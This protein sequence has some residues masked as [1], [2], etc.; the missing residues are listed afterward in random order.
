MTNQLWL[1]PMDELNQNLM[2]NVR[3]SDWTN[4]TPAPK[5]N[6]VVIGAGSAGLVTAAGAAGL[7]AK[8]A[9]VEKR[10]MGGDCL[11]FGCVPSKSL[12]HSAMAGEPFPSAMERMRKLRSR[13]SAHDSAARFRDLGVDVFLGEAQFTG[14]HT[15][16]VG[17]TVLNAKK[18][19]IATGSKPL[20]PPIPGLDQMEYLTNETI[21]SLTE[22]PKRLLVVGGGPIGCELAQVFHRFGAKVSLVEMASHIL[23][24]EEADAAESI[25]TT[26]R[27]EGISLYLASSLGRVS[28]A[29]GIKT[30]TIQTGDHEQTIEFDAILMAVGREPNVEGLHLEAAQVEF[31]AKQGI[32]VNDWLQTTNL[33]IF[34][35]GDCCLRHKFTHTADAS[36]RMVI[37]NALFKGRQKF[38]DL[39]I[40]WCTY[41]QPEVAHVGLYQ[42]EAE[43]QGWQTETI[44]IPFSQV[45]RA[46]LDGEESGFL[47]VLLQQGTDKILGATLVAR[48]AGNLIG[49]LTLAIHQNI[50]LGKIASVI[51]PYPT[52][53]EAIRKA[54][55][56]YNRTRLTPLVKKLFQWWLSLGR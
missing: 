6:L 35:V 51:H 20:I 50:G 38:S 48:H 26:F 9:L 10:L 21:F 28:K 41:T 16:Q 5:Y 11:N 52:Q 54:A 25:Q 19:V 33:N 24:R 29:N 36:A 31:D 53:S 17:D 15:V 2:A 37:R 39:V 23:P 14:S 34:A 7:G 44:T 55:D 42:K 40:P 49:E 4:P 8:V 56:T 3:P 32:C 12:I 13:I 43:E 46:I 30:A 27:Q 22:L 47:K 18:V 45:D 1:Q